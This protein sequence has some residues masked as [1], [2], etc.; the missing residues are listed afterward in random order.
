MQELTIEQRL[1]AIE[2][3]NYISYL[4][5][6]AIAKLLIEGGT[7]KEADLAKQMDELNEKLLNATKEMMAE[8]AK[9]GVDTDVTEGEEG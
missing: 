1:E 4:M 2:S 3:Q 7:I 6:N 9:A 8:A 5:Q